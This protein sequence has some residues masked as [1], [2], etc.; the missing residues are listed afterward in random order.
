[1]AHERIAHALDRLGRRD[2][3]QDRV[4]VEEGISAWPPDDNPPRGAQRQARTPATE[5][6]DHSLDGNDTAEAAAIAAAIEQFLRDT[7]PPPAPC[8]DRDEPWLRAG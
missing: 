7:A 1:V 2:R 8:G 5:D 3:G 6:R 4:V